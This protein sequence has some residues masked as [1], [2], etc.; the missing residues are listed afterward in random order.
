MRNATDQ[1][2]NGLR[3]IQ[4]PVSQRQVIVSGPYD[5]VIKPVLQSTAVGLAFVQGIVAPLVLAVVAGPVVFW[6]CAAVVSLSAFLYT[7]RRSTNWRDKPE[8]VLTLMAAVILSALVGGIAYAV[9][10]V[11]RWVV[12]V[13]LLETPPVLAFAWAVF[14][15]AFLPHLWGSMVQRLVI[16]SMFQDRYIWQALGKILEWF[17][18]REKPRNHRQPMVKTGR[19]TIP[20]ADVEPY[21]PPVEERTGIE[22]FLMLAQQ[23]GTLRRDDNKTDPGLVGKVK[24]DGRELTKREWEA[25][26]AWLVD[27]GWVE[28][29][30]N[31]YDWVPGVDA[32]RVLGQFEY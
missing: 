22:L 19:P 24:R 13:W 26:I 8:R 25:S 1:S 12:P 2:H 10:E 9:A 18:K 11:A 28:S 20:T 32:G 16:P 29:R 3:P 7:L 21:T 17:L 14:A 30:G 4:P 15:V 31:G 27:G 6:M 23:Y 5:T